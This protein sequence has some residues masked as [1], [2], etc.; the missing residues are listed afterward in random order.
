MGMEV[1]KGNREFDY[2]KLVVNML[3]F[4]VIIFLLAISIYID[5]FGFFFP[6]ET[7]GTLEQ[8]GSFGDFVGGMM[9]PLL[10]FIVI[11][12]LF[13]SIQIQQRELALTNET[14]QATREEIKESREATQASAAALQAQAKFQR[15]QLELT[16]IEGVLSKLLLDLED[17]SKRGRFA[18]GLI[19][20]ESL[21][22]LN[23]NEIVLHINKKGYRAICEA[24]SYNDDEENQQILFRV[25]DLLA[26]LQGLLLKYVQEDG[27]QYVVEHWLKNIFPYLV[28]LNKY[29]IVA[30]YSC[31][32]E[33]DKI[34]D[35][36]IDFFACRGVD[37]GFIKDKYSMRSLLY[38]EFCN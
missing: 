2:K 28:F 32:N 15:T 12:M 38:S 34:L 3:W 36:M 16:A 24:T 4:V 37:F 11:A 31:V 30:P 10:Q 9:N 33:H 26:E 22:D 7:L 17:N 29:A 25:H 5:R 23:I 8:F 1:V 13:W 18:I 27:S 6:L 35:A 20:E 19:N 21:F 14:L